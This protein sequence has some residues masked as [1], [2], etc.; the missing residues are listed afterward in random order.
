MRNIALAAFAA[1]LLSTAADA[2]PVLMI[3][4]DGLRPLDVI[5]ADKRGL[6]VPNLRAFMTDGTYATGVRNVLPTVTYP[7]HTTLITGV[8]P[9]VHGIG[10]NVK[11]DP[12][13]RTMTAG[14]VDVFNDQWQQIN[15]LTDGNV[16]AG[17]APFNAQ[18][19]DGHLFVTFAKQDQFKHDDVAGKGNGFVD[20][21]AI[22][23]KLVDRVAS[24]GPPTRPGG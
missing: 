11:F 3:S 7:D 24:H 2:N 14:T 19:L 12:L 4:I 8:W 1:A 5:E 21:L 23:G 10:N 9:N 16:R 17:Y 15:S 22:N 20:K 13:G 6:A 18:V